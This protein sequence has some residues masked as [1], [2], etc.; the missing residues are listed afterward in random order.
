MNEQ[1]E[2]ILEAL[3]DY[4]QNPEDY[5]FYDLE[6]ISRTETLRSFFSHPRKGE[7][8]RLGARVLDS[9]YQVR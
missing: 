5:S 1:D 3:A 9:S 4:Y 6:E 8:T 7:P 2:R